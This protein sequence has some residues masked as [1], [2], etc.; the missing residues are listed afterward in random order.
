MDLLPASTTSPSKNLQKQTLTSL[1]IATVNCTNGKP[2]TEDQDH[3]CTAKERVQNFRK[4]VPPKID[5]FSNQA[6]FEVIVNASGAHSSRG[7]TSSIAN[8]NNVLPNALCNKGNKLQKHQSSKSS[9]TISTCSIQKNDS[10]DVGTLLNEEDH[11]ASNADFNS[12]AN[13]NISASFTL[14]SSSL[15]SNNT[16]LAAAA[17]VVLSL[18]GSMMNS[19][20]Q[21]ALLPL[22]SPAA[23][24]LNLQALESYLAL[25]RLTGKGDVF[26]L[27]NNLSTTSTSSTAYISAASS[28][29]NLHKSTTF[30]SN[31]EL[32]S[33]AESTET[34]DT[35][36]KDNIIMSKEPEKTER[37]PSA[38]NLLKSLQSRSQYISLEYN[39]SCDPPLSE[40]TDASS[41]TF[42]ST[43]DIESNIYL[44]Y[45]RLSSIPQPQNQQQQ[46]VGIKTISNPEHLETISAL[47]S[48][49]FQDK[50]NSQ[51]VTDIEQS[52]ILNANIRNNNLLS[53]SLI[54]SS[55]A[56]SPI[57]CT[58]AVGDNE[59]STINT[60]VNSMIL[61]NV[62]QRAKKQFICKFCHRQFT[63]SYN[64]LIHERTHT[65]ERPYSCDICGKAFRRQDHLRD[66]RYDG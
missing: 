20:Q 46:T 57:Q 61:S 40:E 1:S 13:M 49:M 2:T 36:C 37:L 39:N 60:V 22:N 64:L 14:A 8:I 34:E 16:D 24:A 56:V 31:R 4:T 55:E 23:T 9:R 15:K 62:A 59:A 28:I 30:C 3:S 10:K 47:Q 27:S 7:G 5:L 45:A 51:S 63:K 19:L 35:C 18:Q 48:A 52:D 25:Q 11:C 66:H 53:E 17:A 44:N 6:L 41:L 42:E 33:S 38:Q 65:D 26:R 50:L 58:S 12:K 21:A 43:G 54:R 29:D 32:A